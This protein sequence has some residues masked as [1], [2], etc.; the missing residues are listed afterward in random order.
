MSKHAKISYIFSHSFLVVR[1][2]DLFPFVLA[3]PLQ[4]L[5]SDHASCEHSQYTVETSPSGSSISAEM[6]AELATE[7]VKAAKQA[8]ADALAAG[9]PLPLIRTGRQLKRPCKLRT[10]IASVGCCFTP[11]FNYPNGEL[12]LYHGGALTLLPYHEVFQLT[13]LIR[14]HLC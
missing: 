10:Q 9:R 14:L 1:Y 13:G 7:A 11:P 2:N 3:S 5:R 12:E 6:E 4:I 8:E